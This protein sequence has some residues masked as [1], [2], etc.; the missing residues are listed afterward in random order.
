M[1]ST[2]I[3]LAQ[4]NPRTGD[5]E[6]NVAA[7]KA[8]AEKARSAD[9]DYLICPSGALAG[10][11]LKHLVD[12]F[13]FCRAV[14]AAAAELAEGEADVCIVLHEPALVGPGADATSAWVE[15]AE[16]EVTE[17]GD[18]EGLDGI[19]F[20]PAGPLLLRSMPALTL[21]LELDLDLYE[22]APV[23]TVVVD[24]GVFF[25][26][27]ETDRAALLRSYQLRNDAPLLY[28]NLVGAQDSFVYDGG[29]CALARSGR[30]IAR[31]EDFQEDV[32]VV[33][34]AD[35]GHLAS[36]SGVAQ[37][38]E[39]AEAVYR[40]A[41]VG[42]RDYVQKNG[43]SKV[44][45][46]LSGGIDSA[47]VAAIAA[48]A[49]GG[50]NIIGVSMPSRYSTDHSRSDAD[51]TASRLGLD[52]RVQPIGPIFDAFEGEM[53]LSGIAEENLQAR[54]RGMIL[55]A[56]SNS[57]GAL[58][59]ATGNRTE[60]AVGYSTIYGDSVGGFAPISDIPKTLVWEISRWR[61]E[62]AKQRGEVEPIPEHSITKPPS[63]ELRPGQQDT[64][65][66][67]D[68]P[69]LDAIVT[70]LIDEGASV[71]SLE[72]DGFD[73]ETIDKVA[74]LIKRAEW[75]RGQM[76]IGPKVSKVTFGVDRHY[77]VVN[78]FSTRSQS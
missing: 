57:E 58:V 71:A 47:L 20:T 29:T 75:K 59:L 32:L 31:A 21:D 37:P 2:R 22:V 38:Y 35:D 26:E 65:S 64:N 66:L 7:I 14:T 42:L 60:V 46:G 56:I 3:A 9:A 1:N 10:G 61:N 24:Q 6:R 70:A 34:L 30:V 68:Y 67:P 18:L 48:D 39:R 44:A 73:P 41:T 15:L 62:R 77:P 19:V 4:L 25:T 36:D 17:L 33:D 78:A 27:H 23:A 50:E 54:I 63:A 16:G 55:M 40:A 51:E 12:Q 69:V 5:L 8:A 74:G 45:L 28:T 49:I 76:A 53:D 13:D 43:F 52:Y 11:N 72:R